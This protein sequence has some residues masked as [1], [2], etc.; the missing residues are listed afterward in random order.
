MANETRL[1]SN[2]KASARRA[3]LSAPRRIVEFADYREPSGRALSRIAI[4]YG[5]L[6]SRRR[7][8][9]LGINL[10]PGPSIC[11]F[12]CIYCFRGGAQRHLVSVERDEA[13][14][15]PGRVIRALYHALQRLGS[16]A[17]KLQ[18]I[19]FSGNGEPTLHPRFAEIVKAVR[20]YIDGKGLGI[21]LG[22]FT[23][24]SRLCSPAVRE[25]LPYLDH[26]EA[27]LDTVVPWKFHVINQPAPGIELHNILECLAML[28]GFFHGT[29][30]LQVIL[31]ETDGLTNYWFWDAEQLASL[32]E[33]I[34]PDRVN[35]YTVYAPPRQKIV[36]KA[37]RL[38]MERYATILREHGLDVH[39]YPE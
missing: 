21:S 30:A 2:E 25:A 20:E 18:A 13:G 4:V 16:D 11:S 24:S 29:I 31:L 39:V 3:G 33:K 28:R 5:P 12:N 14:L 34:S 23:N 27:K 19:D 15:D 17:E 36:R 8:F 38:H 9:S 37:P 6:Y 26:V 1:R 35:L 32:A 7:G 22:L 10:F